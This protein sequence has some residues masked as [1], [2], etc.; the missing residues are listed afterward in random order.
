MKK[1]IAQVRSILT[2]Q[3]RPGGWAVIATTGVLS[4]QVTIK[5]SKQAAEEVRDD[6]QVVLDAAYAEAVRMIEDELHGG[7]SDRAT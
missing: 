7:S 3:P 2:V 4:S 6:L 1:R 5:P